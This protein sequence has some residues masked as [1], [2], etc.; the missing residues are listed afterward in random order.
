ML[1][2]GVGL[3]FGHAH[4]FAEQLEV[5]NQR[6]H[7]GL[8]L[9]PRRRRHLVVFGDHRAGIR[10]QPVRALFDDAVGLAHLFHADKIAVV[11]V[12][13]LADRNVEIQAIVDVVGL[14][15]AQIPCHARAAQHRSGHAQVHRPLGGNDPDADRALL[16]DAVVGQQGF[17]FIDIGRKAPG[18]V[19]DEIEQRTLAVLVE[20]VDRARVADL[21][22]AVLRHAVR[23]VAVH[24]TGAEIGS[25]HARTRHRL[26]H[27]EQV[28][29]LAEGVQ[30][31]GHRPAVEAM[32][33]QPHQVVEE[34]G[35]FGEHHPDVLP[36]QR[37]LDAQQLFDRQAVG[38]FVAHHRH[39][40]EAV[41]VG[42]RLDIGLVLGQFFRGAVEQADVRIGTLHHFAVEFEHQAQHA[43]G[44]RVLR[45]E[46][47]GVVL[48][49]G[50]VSVPNH[51]PGHHILA[52]G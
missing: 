7:A 28:F 36:T 41:H 26:V 32:R 3:T 37:H 29:A 17:V 23:Q 42:Q 19:V 35:D 50:H 38:V 33:T 20:I 24:A 8:H 4:A 31:N 47:Q 22:L 18:E 11:A 45:P 43:V 25:V 30:K 21:G 10:A 40:V 12:A 1:D 5:V 27:V 16:P 34:A 46:V 14:G 52:R 39:V 9:F 13:V 15:L 2:S 44:R 51:S 48:D 6:F 49:V